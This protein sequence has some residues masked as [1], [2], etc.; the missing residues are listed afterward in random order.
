MAHKIMQKFISLLLSAALGAGIVA[1]AALTFE[2]A[3]LHARAAE[4]I[5]GHRFLTEND[6]YRL[7]LKEE[8]LSLIIEDKAT[9]T[10]MESAVSYDDGKNNDIWLGAMRS[11]VVLT[12]I[13]KSDDTLQADLLNDQVSKTVTTNDHGFTAELYWKKYS[14]GFTL[15]VGFDNNGLTARIPESSIREDSEQYFIGTIR[16]Y[17]FMGYSYLD[18]KE[19]YMLVPDGNGALI[20]LDD[21]EGRYA[22]GFSGTIY[23]TD[24]GF[25]DSKVETLLW[26]RY[27]TIADA[28]KVLAPVFGIAHTGEGM[29]FLG[30]VE[31]GRERAAIEVVP[32]GASVDY[33]RAYARFVLR[34]LYTQPTSNNSTVGSLRICEA[35][36]SHSDLQVRFLFLSGED[37]DYVG[38][39]AAYRNYL[40]GKGDLEI[41][42]DTYKTRID[43]LG[44]D[45]QSWVLGTQA[46]VM[47]TVDDI[48]EIYGDLQSEGIT[49][50]LSVY[51]GWQK[52][53]LYNLPLTSLSVESKLGGKG[54]LKSLMNSLQGTDTELYLYDNALLINPDETNATFNVIKKVNK[55]RYEYTT[56]KDVYETFYYLTPARSKLLLNRFAKSITSAGTPNLAL[57]GI[58]NN[59]FTYTYSTEKYTRFDCAAVYAEAIDA[60][61][62]GTNLLLEQPISAYW[63]DTSVFLDMP[64]YTSHYI[65]EDESVPFLSLTLKG[66]MPVY[67]EYVN[68]EANGQEFFLKMIETGSYPSFYVTGADSSEL[69]YT[70]SNDVYSSRYESYRGRILEYTE[71]FRDLSSRTAGATV[72]GHV[73]DGDLRIV[74]YS[75]GLKIY[76]NYGTSPRT[77][78]GVTVEGMDYAIVD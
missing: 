33:N 14:L 17:P 77:A 64:L 40:L 38:M 24:I 57:A 63:N 6:G 27:N 43:F 18:D 68:F 13:N 36:R 58:T 69:I 5:D 32:N 25:E 22:S 56:Y 20:Y 55:R 11:A 3:A 66:V 39:A 72:T 2:P 44:S 59:L 50:I 19:G 26:N 12:L 30:I 9:G 28:E 74:T 45:R 75:N 49:D 8:D 47:T 10:I 35:D 46:V 53:G 73:I 29:A 31:D 52:G 61:A 1:G 67:A 4:E 34:R 42:E 60:L 71:V 7:Y 54:D 70:N 78:D 48:K 23:G 62:S 16:I 51:K 37:A 41:R 76:L 65:L 15:E 21:K